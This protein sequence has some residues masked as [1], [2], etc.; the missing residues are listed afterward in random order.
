MTK[1]INLVH[2][3]LNAEGLLSSKLQFFSDPPAPTDLPSDPVPT[4]PPV[5]PNP[6]DPPIDPVKSFSQDDVNNLIARETKKQQEK[7]LK[8]LGIED[9][10]GAKEGLAKLK[11]YQDAQKTEAEKQSEALKALETERESFFNENQ[12][13]KAQLSATKAGVLA[14]SVSDVVT[15]AK[16]MVTDDV[17]MDAAIA[18]VV[19]KYPHFAQVAESAPDPNVP[20]KPQFSNGQHQT[21]PLS[22]ADKWLAAFKQ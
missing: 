19:E 22:D 17:D 5:D 8:D 7:M 3:P 11:E 6:Q 20:P 18:A 1:R 14:D 15:L 10:K 12:T 4:D 13:L 16:T 2:Q 9:F 21:Q